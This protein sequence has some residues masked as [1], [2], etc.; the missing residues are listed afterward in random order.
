MTTL[1]PPSL[2][3]CFEILDLHQMTTRLT[4]GLA[5]A[6]DDNPANRAIAIDGFLAIH[7]DLY[8]VKTAEFYARSS[9]HSFKAVFYGERYLLKM[10]PGPATQT[11]A[12][13]E[14]LT[15]SLNYALPLA[16]FVDPIGN[17]QEIQRRIEIYLEEGLMLYF[18]ALQGQGIEY[19]LDPENKAV[20]MTVSEKAGRGGRFLE[21]IGFAPD[22]SDLPLS[23]D[24]RSPRLLATKTYRELVAKG[25]TPE[26]IVAFAT[27]VIA[28]VT[29]DVKK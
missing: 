7:E 12:G 3:S 22:G 19:N 10:T 11:K 6:F 17:P 2:I 25:L 18:D 8:Q 16:D 29:A 1:A 4:F 28:E 15:L 23:D 24:L 21:R 13:V 27:E 20:H 9:P 5:G 14:D 26:Q